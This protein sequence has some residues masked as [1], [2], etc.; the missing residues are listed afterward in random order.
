M[1]DIL[2]EM[3]VHSSPEKCQRYGDDDD[4]ASVLG[5][6]LTQLQATTVAIPDAQ[7]HPFIHSI[8]SLYF[9]PCA[10]KYSSSCSFEPSKLLG[11]SWNSSILSI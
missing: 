10:I 8:G 4:D 1:V 11:S 6:I 9:L 5:T 7:L 2:M 3:W